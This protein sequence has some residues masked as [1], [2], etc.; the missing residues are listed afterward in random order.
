MDNKS[1]NQGNF[2]LGFFLGGLIGGFI[3]YLMGTKNGKKLLEKVIDQTELYEEEI[4]EKLSSLQEKGEDLLSEAENVKNKISQQ[5]ST[6]KKNISS[7]LITKMD[8]TLGKIEDIQKK[9]IELTEE[10][11]HNYFRKNGKKLSS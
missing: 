8:E 2:W 1:N 5:V 9:G 4:E 3:I 7:T 10:V 11:R 6:G